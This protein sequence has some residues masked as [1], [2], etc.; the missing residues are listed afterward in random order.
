MRAANTCY[1]GTEQLTDF[2]RWPGSGSRC[3]G[4]EWLKAI[5]SW[6]RLPLGMIES[7]GAERVD[8][9]DGSSLTHAHDGF[10]TMRPKVQ[11]N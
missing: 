6:L 7:D 1:L 3:N 10:L 4:V 8:T 5:S 2:E 9:Q 11:Q